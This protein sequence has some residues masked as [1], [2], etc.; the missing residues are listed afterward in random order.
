MHKKTTI[1][2]ILSDFPTLSFV[3][4]GDSGEKDLLIYQDIVTNFPNRI[5]LVLIRDVGNAD[6][7]AAA[8]NSMNYFQSPVPFRLV[9]NHE[10]SIQICKELYLL[11]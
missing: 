3:L 5:K 8:Q 1:T 10:Q 4:V 7:A 2:R 6:K 11:P 9:S